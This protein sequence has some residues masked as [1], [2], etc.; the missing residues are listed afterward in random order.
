METR[1]DPARILNSWGLGVAT[2][3]VAAGFPWGKRKQPEFPMG[4]FPIGTTKCTKKTK[5][6]VPPQKTPQIWFEKELI[7]DHLVKVRA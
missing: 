4:K 2:L 3:S 7:T 6:I 1:K 5:K